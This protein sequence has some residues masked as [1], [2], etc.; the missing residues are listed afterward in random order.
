L[1]HQPIDARKAPA[2]QEVLHML[3][4]DGDPSI[5][6]NL[7]ERSGRNKAFFEGA[8]AA[9]WRQN[10]E[11][12]LRVG[13]LLHQAKDELDPDVFGALKLPFVPRVSQMLR[14]IA[15][16]PIIANAN[17]GSSL[18]ACWRTLY[19]LTKVDNNILVVALADG[20][21]HPGLARK[22]IRSEILG[23][24]PSG[25]KGSKPA[26]DL[27]TVLA[28]ASATDAT[29]ALAGLGMDWFLQRMPV[30]W[31]AEMQA[32][33]DRLHASQDRNTHKAEPAGKLT[34]FLR[35]AV[36]LIATADLPETS[37]A[38]ATANKNEA[39]AALRCA[40]AVLVCKGL[41]VNDLVVS[42][43]GAAKTKPRARAA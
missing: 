28:G 39:I 43:K 6:I 37:P 34:P 29:A 16:H 24:P 41:D 23:L 33:V 4:I 42:T 3:S 30:D 35:K 15:A 10:V 1:V 13:Q 21:I 22:D 27:A 14:R 31:R 26:T 17:H 5:E 38:T 40:I 32:R 20:R 18:P 19:E 11:G 8:I 36:S 25:A 7:A 9:E 2:A 12:I